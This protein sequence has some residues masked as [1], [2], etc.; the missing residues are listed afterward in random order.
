MEIRSS[1]SEYMKEDFDAWTNL[2]N[3]RSTKTQVI[4]EDQAIKRCP[5]EL[6]LLTYKQISQNFQDY[7]LWLRTSPLLSWWPPCCFTQTAGSSGHYRQSPLGLTK[8]AGKQRTLHVHAS[9][10]AASVASWPSSIFVKFRWSSFQLFKHVYV[11]A[12]IASRSLVRRTLVTSTQWGKHDLRLKLGK[13]RWFHW[14]DVIHSLL[15]LFLNTFVTKLHDWDDVRRYVIQCKP[16][17]NS[18]ASRQPSKLLR[19]TRFTSMT[20]YN[21]HS[22]IGMAL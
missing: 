5:E 3:F 8:L 14:I 21:L 4:V 9:R 18:A 11:L 7:S 17:R 19:Q 2:D 1:T 6:T 16:A 15:Q 22:C 10:Q 13:T 12:E 20:E